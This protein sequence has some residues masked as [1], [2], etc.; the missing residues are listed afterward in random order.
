MPSDS[1]EMFRLLIHN[2]RHWQAIYD[3][4]HRFSGEFLSNSISNCGLITKT[5]NRWFRFCAEN[6]DSTHIGE[7]NRVK[8]N[9][10]RASIIYGRC[11]LEC[12]SSHGRNGITIHRASSLSLRENVSF[13][14][15][16]PWY[17]RGTEER[18]ITRFRSLRERQ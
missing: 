3:R 11:C 15:D 12:T 10:R 16:S 7:Q 2:S 1:L 18:P 8:T 4:R 9:V 17:L 13:L 6:I 5:L 14:R